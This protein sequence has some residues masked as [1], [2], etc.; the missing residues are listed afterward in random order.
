VPRIGVLLNSSR[1][2]NLRD[3]R[4]GLRELGYIEG[5]TIALNVLTEKG[6]YGDYSLHQDGSLVKVQKPSL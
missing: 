3:L 5:Q 6:H 1:T 4:E 2:E